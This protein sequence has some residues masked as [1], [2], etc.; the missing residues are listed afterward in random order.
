LLHPRS[1][2]PT[3]SHYFLADL[4]RRKTLLRVYTQNIDSL[5]RLSGVGSGRVVY[6]HGSLLSGRGRRGHRR[7]GV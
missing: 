1:V 4:H 3:P 2:E 7:S 6:A 5:E